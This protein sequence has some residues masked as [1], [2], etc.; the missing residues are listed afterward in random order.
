MSQR[1]E[2]REVY[3]CFRGHPIPCA[4]DFPDT[5]NI[6]FNPGTTEIDGRSLHLNDGAVD[7]VVRAVEA[8]LLSHLALPPGPSDSPRAPAGRTPGTA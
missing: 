4:A 3:Q 7:A 6:V 5:V 2:P 8:R 1:T